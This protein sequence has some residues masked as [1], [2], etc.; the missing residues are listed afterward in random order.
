MVHRERQSFHPPQV[1]TQAPYPPPFCSSGAS[2]LPGV[3]FHYLGNPTSPFKAQLRAALPGSFL[4][5]PNPWEP[6]SC[7]VPPGGAWWGADVHGGPGAQLEISGPSSR[8]YMEKNPGSRGQGYWPECQ[9][10]AH[11]VQAKGD[12][13]AAIA[14]TRQ[15][16]AFCE[17]QCNPRGRPQFPCLYS[18]TRCLVRASQPQ[19]SCL[20]DAEMRC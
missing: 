19:P 13:A 14:S 8:A 16:A 5:P 11:W 10:W 6:P 12:F 15:G 9:E 18:G 4:V 7:R 1:Q 3:V 2:C 20:C 17:W